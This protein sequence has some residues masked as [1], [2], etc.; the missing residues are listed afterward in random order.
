MVG[1]IGMFTVSPRGKVVSANN[2]IMDLLD[3]DQTNQVKDI[4]IQ[5]FLTR[6]ISLTLDPPRAQAAIDVGI[7]NVSDFPAINLK[8][9]AGNMDFIQLFLFP[10]DFETNFAWGGLIIDRSVE[11][12]GFLQ[13][14]NIMTILSM[15]ARKSSASLEGNLNALSVNLDKW[16]REIVREFVSSIKQEVS[17]INCQ[18]DQLLLFENSLDQFQIYPEFLKIDDLIES[19]LKSDQD[20]SDRFIKDSSTPEVPLSIQVDPNLTKTA[21]DFL[22]QHMAKTIPSSQHIKISIQEEDGHLKVIFT[23]NM[24]LTLPGLP[25]QLIQVDPNDFDIQ[26]HLAQKIISAQNGSVVIENRSMESRPGLKMTISLPIIVQDQTQRVK[27]YHDPNQRAAGRVLVAESHSEYQT[28]ITQALEDLG[29]RVDLAIEGSAVLD[30]AQRINPDL[31][32]IERNLPG[33]DGILVTQGIRRWSSIPI[34]M[35]S[36][37]R[38]IDD[39]IN[40]FQAGV[41]DYIAK[42]FQVDEL[43][44]RVQAGVRRGK[45]SGAAFTPDIF[46]SGDV[47]INYSTRQVWIR[48]QQVSL[49]PIEFNILNYMSR[50]RRQVMPYDQIIERAWEGPEK[51]T[52]QG[53]FV[54]VRRL[55]DK[56]ELDPK[57]P[58]IILNEW[59]VGYLFSP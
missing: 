39:L 1:S 49:T 45:D 55:R 58:R 59:G 54:H 44:V 13:Q 46:T 12:T 3:M 28:L 43:I 19:I 15:E 26:L 2:W 34:I 16:T 22:L 51:G 35:L 57:N 21:F 32:I 9:A 10:G 52:R 38:G 14:L 56:I 36:S 24:P 4:P 23:G 18:L 53:L 25:D 29:Y 40:S 30:M 42:P 5:E 41:D 50:H 8:I 33:L 31:I 47:S 37:R 20:L 6:L 48:S 11:R 27:G 17:S 7:E